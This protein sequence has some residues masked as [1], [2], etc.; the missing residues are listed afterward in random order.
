MSILS[1][2]KMNEELLPS[3]M[4]DGAL[5]F[6]PDSGNIY[7]DTFNDQ[8]NVIERVRICSTSIK[9][10]IIVDEESGIEIYAQDILTKINETEYIPTSDYHPAT[11]KYVDDKTEYFVSSPK[12]S[13]TNHV[14]MYSDTTGQ[15]I[16]DSGYTIE[17]SVP[18]NAK[19]T[20]TTYELV[21]QT[22][23]G[24]MSPEDKTKLDKMKVEAWTLTLEDGS[25]VVKNM[26]VSI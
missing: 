18:P 23:A 10:N 7:I 16:I 8:T 2:Y 19:F 3:F 9:S 25:T 20:D 5:W 14:A 11:K 12:Y 1:L 15:Y 4:V 26:V 13:E 24:L 22:L 17:S 21:T 6:C